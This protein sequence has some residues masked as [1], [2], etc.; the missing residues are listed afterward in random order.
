M[1]YYVYM[2]SNKT[3]STLYVGVTSDLVKRIYEHKHG[4]FEGFSDKYNLHKLVYYEFFDNIDLAIEREK[5]LKKKKREN[6]NILVYKFNPEWRDLY[7]D[8]CE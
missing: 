1:Q 3:D 5:Q 4:V 7:G 2:I 8:I 6:K